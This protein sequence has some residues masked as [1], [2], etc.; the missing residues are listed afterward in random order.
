M[1]MTCTEGAGEAAQRGA[2]LRGAQGRC[3]RHCVLRGADAPAARPRRPHE[4]P[5]ARVAAVAARDRPLAPRA[6]PPPA[7]A[8]ARQGRHLRGARKG[9]AA[10]GVWLH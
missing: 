10:A 5:H 8:H 3:C 7:L 1:R 4:H 6:L 9:A 2:V